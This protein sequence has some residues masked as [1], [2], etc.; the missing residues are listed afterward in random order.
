MPVRIFVNPYFIS[1]EVT[2]VRNIGLKPLC[3]IYSVM[4]FKKCVSN[5][6]P[7]R[8][9]DRPTKHEIRGRRALSLRPS[10]GGPRHSPRLAFASVPLDERKEST[11]IP[12]SLLCFPSLLTREQVRDRLSK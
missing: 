4:I 2:S 8:C 12:P 3:Y 11:P 1:T 6:P 10:R 7:S 9:C 5:Y